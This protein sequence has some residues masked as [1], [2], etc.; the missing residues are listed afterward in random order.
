[1]DALCKEY[2]HRYIKVHKVEREGLLEQLR[3]VP[4]GIAEHPKLTEPTPA[5]PDIYK[6]SSVVESYRN[7][8][9]GD[10]RKFA[11]WKNRNV[12]EWF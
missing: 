3:F 4:S 2:T 7:Y 10:K 6:V 11:T 9:R 12:P 5:M 1:M 8:Y